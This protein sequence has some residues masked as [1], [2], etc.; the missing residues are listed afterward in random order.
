MRLVDDQQGVMLAACLRKLVDRCKI[1]VHG[2]HGVGDHDRP[3]GRRGEQL[4]H[5]VNIAV[6]VNLDQRTEVFRKPAAIDYRGVVQLVRTDENLRPGNRR[7][8]AQVCGE[9]CW[10]NQG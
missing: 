9:A 8:Q 3:P 5:R 2:K 10:E 7:Q 4:R 1:A 6:G